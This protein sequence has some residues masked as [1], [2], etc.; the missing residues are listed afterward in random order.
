MLMPERESILNR[1]VAPLKNLKDECMRTTCVQWAKH[2]LLTVIAL[3]GAT[4][5]RVDGTVAAQSTNPLA[6]PL[7]SFEHVQYVG[8]FRL[9][10]GMNNGDSFSFGGRQI[11]FNPENNSL[12]VG[13]KDGRVAEVTIPGIVR[14]SNP[15]ALQMATFRQGFFDPTEGRLAQVGTEGV[16]LDSLMVHGGRLYGTAFVYYDATNAQRVS[17]FSRSLTLNQSSFQGWSAVWQPDKTGYVSGVMAALPGEWQSVLGGAAITGQCC[18]PI[19][20]RTSWGPSAFSFNPSR[21]GESVVPASP[22]L[23]YTKEHPTLGSWDASSPVY[24]ATMSMGGLVVVPGTRTALYFGANGTGENCYGNGTGDPALHKT[25]GG[26][27]ALYCYDP[28]DTSKGS[29]A[30]PYRYQIWAYDLADFAAVKAG[31]KQPWDVKPY[32]VWPF[33]LPTQSSKVR[34]GGVGYDQATGKL[35]LSQL[36]AD[37]DGYSYR[38][39][40]HQL[41]ITLHEPVAASR[42]ALT[43]SLNA[44]RTAPLASGTTVRFNA[45]P[46]GGTNPVQFKWLTFDG[47]TWTARTGWSTSSDFVYTPASAMPDF[48]VAVWARSAQSIA[49][50]GEATASLD[51][52]VTSPESRV[53]SVSLAHDK[54]PPQPPGTSITWSA[55]T[56]GGASP[57]FKWFVHDGTA[58]T[59]VRDWS[60]SS[61]YVWTPSASAP[62]YRVSVW[63][64]SG[65]STEVYE[66]LTEAYFAIEAPTS[67]RPRVSTVSLRP[68]VASPQPPNTTITWTATTAGGAAPQ[69]KW[70]VFSNGTWTMVRD[71]SASNSFAWTPTTSG[72]DY[73]VS[74][75]ARS[76]GSSEYYEA[77]TEEYFTIA[78]PSAAPSRVSSVVLTSDKIAPQRE[79]TTITFTARATGGVGP[80]QYRFFVIEGGQ[81][82]SHPWT[83]SN[84]FTWVPTAA[85]PYYRISVWVK[86]A[87]NPADIYEALTEVYFPIE[88]R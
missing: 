51:L 20:T 81:T 2:V 46:D 67:P 77:I 3:A 71:W 9:P 85:R 14:S 30:Y 4:G 32:G 82:T 27:G 37:Q 75:W 28:T 23:Y 35:Y 79:N 21:I 88:R 73:R 26:D 55:I 80:L 11:A 84:T 70:H 8:G 6:L 59:M 10:S 65:G 1:R 22:L 42:K 76:A 60:P 16:S 25:V 44:D 52:P 68:N 48:K 58:W 43:V 13:S 54:R 38:P 47:K 34:L 78:V 57:Q 63:A 12:F 31:T 15:D 86:S 39:V 45:T 53:A 50:T 7:L 64:R 66:A 19:V 29:H 61:T 69:F 36:Y 62:N 33:D 72:S 83:T 41:Q 5:A 40:I 17:H 87:G 18:I 49:E 24:G 56:S 74:V